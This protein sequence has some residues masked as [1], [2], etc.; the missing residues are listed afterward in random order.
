M[1]AGGKRGTDCTVGATGNAGL[2]GLDEHASRTRAETLVLVVEVA[3]YAA[4]AGC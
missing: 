2:I 1:E 3:G 4:E